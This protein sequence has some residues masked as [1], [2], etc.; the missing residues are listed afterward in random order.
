[1][2]TA[3]GLNPGPHEQQQAD[4]RQQAALQAIAVGSFLSNGHTDYVIDLN[5]DVTLTANGAGS[6]AS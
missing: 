5:N 1:M 3:S 2:R 4:R 6:S